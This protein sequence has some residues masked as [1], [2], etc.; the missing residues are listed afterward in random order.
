MCYNGPGESEDSVAGYKVLIDDNFHYMDESERV[1]HG[2]F[3]TADEAVAAC[4]RIVDECLEPM[5]QRGITA[6]A[7]YEQYEGFGD[8]PF[9]MPVDPADARVAFSAWA[10]A[11]ERCEVLGAKQPLAFP[12]DWQDVTADHVGTVI[13]IVGVKPTK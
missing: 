5:L 8:D 3:D 4:K 10:Y 13:S 7:L 11:K 12:A 6:A 1:E 2:V 9:V